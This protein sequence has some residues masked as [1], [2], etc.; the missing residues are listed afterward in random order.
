M[1]SL[2]TLDPYVFFEL[3]TYL[4][5]S[6]SNYCV[7]WSFLLGILARPPQPVYYDSQVTPLSKLSAPIQLFVDK[8][9]RRRREKVRGLPLPPLFG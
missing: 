3:L 4:Y 9:E 6:C 5:C 8:K 7:I 2:P 1:R